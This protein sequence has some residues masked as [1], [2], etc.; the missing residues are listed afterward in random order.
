MKHNPGVD[1]H[2]EE[3]SLFSQSVWGQPSMS[4][5][6]HIKSSWGSQLELLTS[7]VGD[8]SLI[9]Q[10]LRIHSSPVVLKHSCHGSIHKKQCVNKYKLAAED[11]DTTYWL[12][13]KQKQLQLVVVAPYK[14]TLPFEVRLKKT[15]KAS[16][17]HLPASTRWFVRRIDREVYCLWR[18]SFIQL[19]LNDESRDQF[20]LK[21][22]PSLCLDKGGNKIILN[23]WSKRKK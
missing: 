21:E 3:S 22:D 16:R 8:L 7:S 23:K 13:R 18:F 17:K 5:R 19:I 4:H 20:T 1:F 12:L 2:W 14:K 6:K 15:G 10:V 11:L 9:V